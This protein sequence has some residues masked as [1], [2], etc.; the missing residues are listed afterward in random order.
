M[1]VLI[2]D[3]FLYMGTDMHRHRPYGA[4]HMIAFAYLL[5]RLLVLAFWGRLDE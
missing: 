2:D 5:I 4:V 3:R 1:H